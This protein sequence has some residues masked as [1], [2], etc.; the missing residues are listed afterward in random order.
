MKAHVVTAAEPHRKKFIARALPA[1]MAAGEVVW[2]LSPA[3]P[4]GAQGSGESGPAVPVAG[5]APGHGLA[6]FNHPGADRIL[7]E[8]GRRPRVKVIAR[9][10]EDTIC[11]RPV[12]PSGRLGLKTPGTHAMRSSDV[13]R[14][15]SSSPPHPKEPTCIE[16]NQPL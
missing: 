16:S 5:E 4:A 9:R 8:R 1:A 6:D 13:A 10:Q 14:R 12:G 11:F 15:N 3:F 2:G 7:Q